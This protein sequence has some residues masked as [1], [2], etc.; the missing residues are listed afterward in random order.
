[1]GE[2]NSFGFITA[3]VFPQKVYKLIHSAS[4]MIHVAYM[5]G[6]SLSAPLMMFSWRSSAEKQSVTV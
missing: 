4:A 5:I 1:M 6:T 2:F 3:S